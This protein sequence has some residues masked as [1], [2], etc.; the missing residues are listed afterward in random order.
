MTEIKE[1]PFQYLGQPKHIA[2][3]M[4]AD[5]F[6]IQRK[7]AGEAILKILREDSYPLRRMHTKGSLV[8]KAAAMQRD[9]RILQEYYGER[10]ADTSFL[11]AKNTQGKP[12]IVI[13]QKKIYGKTIK[14]LQQQG[15]ISP[16]LDREWIKIEA[17]QAKL[18]RDPRL[19]HYPQDAFELSYEGNIIVEPQGSTKI[20]DW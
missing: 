5:I 3:G 10:I 8:E 20:I 4:D 1:L 9:F 18:R 13:Y 6:E 19:S 16:V 11:V 15:Q 2:R 17:I 12:C 14:Q 7:D